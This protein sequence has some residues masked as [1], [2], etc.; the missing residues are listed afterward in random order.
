MAFS[1]GDPWEYTPPLS[2]WKLVEQNV[3]PKEQDEIRSMLGTSLIDTTLELHSEV[4]H[5]NSR[6]CYF[7]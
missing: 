6:I 5:G 2:L 4:N 7:L 3:S 1:T